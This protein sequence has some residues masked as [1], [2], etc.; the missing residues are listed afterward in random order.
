[1]A[2]AAT[3]ILKTAIEELITGRGRFLKKGRGCTT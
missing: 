2:G 3:I 1:M